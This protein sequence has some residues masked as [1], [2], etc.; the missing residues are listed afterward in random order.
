MS[1]SKSP[2]ARMSPEEEQEVFFMREKPAP[3]PFSQF[4]YNSKEGTVLGRTAMSWG[5]RFFLAYIK[6]VLLVNRTY[7][8]Q[9]C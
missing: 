4:L 2:T 7:S 5:K 1:K 6:C 3:I 9:E 8:W